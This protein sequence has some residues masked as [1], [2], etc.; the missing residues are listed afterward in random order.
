MEF[1]VEI[2]ISLPP[3]IDESERPQLIA[4]ERLRGEELVDSGCLVSLWR[5]SGQQANVGLWAA[6][7]ATALREAICSLPLFPW[8]DVRVTAL[9]THPLQ[10]S[11]R[12]P[13]SVSQ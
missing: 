11:D 3:D 7:D 9:A 10:Q 8:F 5:V 6:T 2:K 13:V 4:A 12:I 1:L